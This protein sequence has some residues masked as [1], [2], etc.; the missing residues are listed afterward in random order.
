MRSQDT[1]VIRGFLI[2]ETHRRNN[3]TGLSYDASALSP[4]MFTTNNHSSTLLAG[5]RFTVMCLLPLLRTVI[6]ST[7]VVT[8]EWVLGADL[9]R[10]NGPNFHKGHRPQNQQQLSQH[11]SHGNLPSDKVFTPTFR[12][13]L[14]RSIGLQFQ[15]LFAILQDSALLV[16]N[17][18]KL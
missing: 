8:A 6:D 16:T 7:D 13:T 5:R 18:R 10:L 3:T 2:R 17:L 9:L 4:L 14:H 12:F 15:S 11:I 1:V